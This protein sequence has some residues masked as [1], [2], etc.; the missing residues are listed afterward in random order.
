MSVWSVPRVAQAAEEWAWIPPGAA[1]VETPEYLLSVMPG[2]YSLTYVHRFRSAP[3]RAEEKIDEV[4]DRVR[5]EGGN[6][7]RWVVRASSA[8]EDLGAR[9]LRRGFAKTETAEVL[10]FELG[11]TERPHRLRFRRA[12]TLS[13]REARSDEEYDTFRHLGEAV[14]GD[15]PPTDEVVRKFR[16]EFHS[17]VETTGHS[18]RF[19]VYDR[20]LPIGRGGLEVS[21]PV[22]R[23]WGAGVLPEHRGCGAYLA[24]TAARCE[25]TREEDGE[26]VLTVARTGTSG[27]I[28]KSHGFREAGPQVTYELRWER[29]GP[30]AG[31]VAS[32]ACPGPGPI[33]GPGSRG[34]PAAVR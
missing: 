28:L 25:A 1:R 26:I 4:L 27:P 16:T 33:T 7:L 23:L 6:G 8:P 19:L 29:E 30:S 9:L 12:D 11:P 10:Y 14:F 2:A 15:P 20:E 17:L 13:T 24:V 32:P 34:S 5:S 21:G 31:R 22:G 3:D 18:G